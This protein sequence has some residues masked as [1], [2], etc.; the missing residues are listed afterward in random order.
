[1]RL[2]TKYAHFRNSHNPLALT[3]VAPM[4]ILRKDEG[5]R[6]PDRCACYAEAVG[7]GQMAIFANLP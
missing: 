5:D 1:M 6:I 2:R 4:N 7:V 3:Q